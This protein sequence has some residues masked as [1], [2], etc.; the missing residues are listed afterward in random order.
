MG[1]LD[2]AQN[3]RLQT[4]W[5]ACVAIV[6]SILMGCGGSNSGAGGGE[7]GA[8]GG[9][10]GNPECVTSN[11]C[12]APEVCEPVTQT[13]VAPLAPCASQAECTGGTYCE[14]MAEVCLPS[15]V[16]TPC[17]GPDNC[18]AECLNGF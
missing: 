18:N 5:T 6:L 3:L 9:A 15:S 17:A 1:N 16:G 14:A 11:Q 4:V 12:V 10:R 2:A 13:C 8:G 7:A